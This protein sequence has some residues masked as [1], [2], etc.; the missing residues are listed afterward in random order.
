LIGRILAVSPH[1]MFLESAISTYDLI[2]SDDRSSLKRETL[3]DYLMIN[4][5]MPP[6][7]SI[8][9]QPAVFKFVHDKNRRPQKNFTMSTFKKQ[10]YY[11]GF[12]PKAEH[13]S[14]NKAKR[15]IDLKPMF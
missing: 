2:K 15:K 4:L 14:D 11:H 6:L 13:D 12:F 5:N 9:L 7:T 10:E 3:N 1:N 8:D